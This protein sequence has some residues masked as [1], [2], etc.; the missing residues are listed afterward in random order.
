VLVLAMTHALTAGLRVSRRARRKSG[1]DRPAWLVS[2]ATRALP[3]EQH[4]WASAMR[5]ELAHVDGSRARWQFSVGCA[6][7][8]GRIWA[9]A[10][11]TA[12]E[13]V[14]VCTVAAGVV[15]SVA[16]A[17]YGLTRY[18]EP[19]A[20]HDTWAAIAAFATLL[21]IY[22][23]ITL[24]LSGSA[25][26]PA[27]TARRYGVAGGVAL[28]CAWFLILSP[29]APL[30]QWVLAPVG[31]ALLGPACVAALAARSGQTVIAGTRAALWSGIVGG[32]LAFVVWMTATYARDGR[33]YDAGLL[34]DFHHS[35]SSHL[36]TYAVRNAFGTGLLALLLIP[37]VALAFGS[38]G[39]RLPNA[40][41]TS[42]PTARETG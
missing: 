39:A 5:A 17:A 4:D 34:R 3:A 36:A 6:W 31:V 1:E 18:P 9:R 21:I 27:D 22:A 15:A 19:L 38:L 14:G 30:K 25:T 32:L 35:G 12:P 20:G 41:N 2:V 33:P 29:P 42:S 11:A 23:L 10:T 37:V 16:L 24:A 28:G 8:A 13:R 40:P 26:R 7:A